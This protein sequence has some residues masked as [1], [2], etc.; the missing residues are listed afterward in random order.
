MT[1]PITNDSSDA[2]LPMTTTSTSS[3]F[4]EHE[5]AYQ[6]IKI[7]IQDGM[8]MSEVDAALADLRCIFDKYLELPSLLDKHIEKM[9]TQLT[10][11]ARD[12]M[13]DVKVLDSPENFWASPLSRQFSALYALSKVRGRKRIQ[14]Q[15]PIVSRTFM[16]SCVPCEPWIKYISLLLMLRKNLQWRR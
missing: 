15:L 1:S 2:V 5:T 4:A 7:L 9:V 10:T 13:E 16:S 11:A 14:K 3:V 8:A 6:K 12:I